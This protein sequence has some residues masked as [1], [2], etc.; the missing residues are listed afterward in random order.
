[1]LEVANSEGFEEAVERVSTAAWG[2]IEKGRQ[3]VTQTFEWVGERFSGPGL[4]SKIVASGS[5]GNVG[6][7]IGFERGR[8]AIDGGSE[9]PMTIRVT[10]IYRREDGEWKLVHRHADFPPKDP[11]G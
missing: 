11:R 4:E 8:A 3:R 10:H 5:S 9:Q 7:T 6:Y 2:P 1:M